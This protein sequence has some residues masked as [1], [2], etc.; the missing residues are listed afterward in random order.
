MTNKIYYSPSTGGFYESEYNTDIPVDKIEITED[1]RTNLLN[2]H[3]SG[4]LIIIGSGGKPT[5][6]APVITA[7]QLRANAISQIGL[8]FDT[9]IKAGFTTSFG[10]KLDCDMQDIL[11]LKG[12]Y[13][14][15]I[16]MEQDEL[17]MLGDYNNGGH[18]NVPVADL[19]QMIKELGA[20]YQSLFQTKMN[21]LA[22][23]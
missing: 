1:E 3:Y 5:A 4:K 22:S 11:N 16:L 23:V 17:E 14:F 2:A 10:I 18:A 13:D 19:L 8:T 6:I 20:H 7:E 12:I 15:C 21:S 9:A